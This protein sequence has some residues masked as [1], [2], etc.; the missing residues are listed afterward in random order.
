MQVTW[1]VT[2]VE[3]AL[4]HIK[5]YQVI[6]EGIWHFEYT[7]LFCRFCR[8]TIVED[9]LVVLCFTSCCFMLALAV[10]HLPRLK[11]QISSDRSTALSCFQPT[12]VSF[13][14]TTTTT[15]HTP[16]TSWRVSDN[17]SWAKAIEMVW[18]IYLPLELTHTQKCHLW[19]SGMNHVVFPF[20]LTG[21]ST[22]SC[23]IGW[24]CKR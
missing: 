16:T 5:T 19:Q 18:S 7:S 14:T 3:F 4:D 21:P 2:S 1:R 22:A 15:T 11:M 17:T 20:V 6:P 9:V 12:G 8:V 10:P 24:D 23:D 13:T